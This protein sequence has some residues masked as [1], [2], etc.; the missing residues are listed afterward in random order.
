VTDVP[1]DT[2][3][4]LDLITSEHADKPNFVA[5]LT[6][7]IEPIAEIIEE[8]CRLDGLFDIDTAVGVQLDVDGQWVGAS[9]NLLLPLT[10]VYFSW[11][12]AGIGWGEGHWKGPF[13]PS[14]GLATLSDDDYRAYLKAT[15]LAN[16]WDGTVSGLYAI[17]ETLIG[18]IGAFQM[19]DDF[20]VPLLDDD[21]VPIGQTAQVN[22]LIQDNGDMSFDLIFV[23]DIPVI[24]AALITG[25][26]LK[27]K[28]AG[29]RMNVITASVPPLL[30][31]WGMETGEVGGWGEGSWPTTLASL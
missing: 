21:G 6:A 1:P 5:S 27:I 14:E 26:Y 31:G 28:P 9:R 2:Q 23:G 30:F 24:P 25:G 12:V 20:G 29:V 16:Q 17:L 7:L 3:A 22:F 18:G 13:D 19:L 4:Y 15:I 11:G 10:G 8:Q